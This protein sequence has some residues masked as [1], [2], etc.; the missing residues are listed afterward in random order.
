MVRH[1]AAYFMARKNEIGHIPKCE[2]QKPEAAKK[3][4]LF[5]AVWIDSRQSINTTVASTFLSWIKH[6]WHDERN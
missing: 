5:T 1:R 2:Q 4:L 3:Q 6:W